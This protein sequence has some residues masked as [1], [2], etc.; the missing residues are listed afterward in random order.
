MENW[1]ILGYNLQII[2]SYNTL[3][4]EVKNSTPNK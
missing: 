1:Q 2:Q 4:Y 3:L